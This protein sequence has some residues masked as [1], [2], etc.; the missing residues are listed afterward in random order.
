MAKLFAAHPLEQFFEGLKTPPGDGV[1]VRSIEGKG[2]IHLFAAKGKTAAIERAL[3]IKETP[4]KAS[5]ANGFNAIPMAPGQWILVSGRGDVRGTFA[6]DIAVKVKKIGYVSEQSDSRVTFRVNGPR[7]IELLQKGCR[8]DLHPDN[9]GKGWCAQTQM[10]QIGV[11]IHQIDEK[12]TFDLYVYSG[13]AR[14]FA[15]WLEY[16]GAQLGITFSR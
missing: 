8:L 2:I 7:V 3:K 5:I 6:A 1:L 12:P 4:G 11:L 9:I 14:E 10:A 13:F 16:T 15:E